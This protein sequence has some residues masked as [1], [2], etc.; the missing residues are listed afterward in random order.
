M[1]TEESPNPDYS[2]SVKLGIRANGRFVIAHATRDRKLSHDVRELVKRIAADDGY[3]VSITVPE[4]PGQAGKEQAAS[5]IAMLRG[6]KAS[7]RR[8][9]TDKVS[10]A[11]PCASQWQAGNFDVVAGPWND[12]LLTELHSFPDVKSHDDQVDALSDAFAHLSK[13]KGGFA[14]SSWKPA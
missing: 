2:S 7:A 13:P 1:A 3:D 5:Y 10:R 4:D 11:E 8:P 6:F 12:V 14:M 9:G